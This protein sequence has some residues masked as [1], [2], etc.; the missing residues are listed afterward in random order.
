MKNS[1]YI[2]LSASILLMTSCSSHKLPV[3]GSYTVMGVDLD[4]LSGLCFNR[5]RTEL[6]ACG[7]RGVIKSVSFDGD[8]TDLFSNPSDMEGITI[9][10]SNGDIYIAVE[11]KQEIHRLLAPDYNTHE[12]MFPIEEAVVEE[13]ANDGLEAV[14][15]YKDNKLF[16]GSQRYSN[17]W[18]CETNGRILSKISLSDFAE[19]VAG[20]HYDSEADWLWV[21]DSRKSLMYICKVDGTLLASYDISF[22]DNAESICVDRAAGAVWVG[23][24]EKETKLYRIDF[25]F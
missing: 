21:T 14:E 3:M 24:D 10:P 4:E 25:E 7:D 12:V 1:F 22:I 19:E 16:A 23:S 5:T 6:I 11:G 2:L 17:I 18:I 8:A 9:N 13:Y 15:Y 20:L